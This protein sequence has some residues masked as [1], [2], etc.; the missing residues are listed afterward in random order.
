M[1]VSFRSTFYNMQIISM[2]LTINYEV[3]ADVIND[4]PSSIRTIWKSGSDMT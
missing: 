4:I 2:K 1:Q 3:T